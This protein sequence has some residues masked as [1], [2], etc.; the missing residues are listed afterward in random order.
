MEPIRLDFDGARLE[1]AARSSN[2]AV[3]MLFSEVYFYHALD[4][5]VDEF[6]ISLQI[7]GFDLISGDLSFSGRVIS[8]FSLAETGVATWHTLIPCP[9]TIGA[10]RLSIEFNSA[11]KVDIK[12]QAGAISVVE[13]VRVHRRSEQS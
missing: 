6:K 8:S 1:T 5:L 11:E 12:G 9:C 3:D 4:D 10:F 13:R 7:D 2:G